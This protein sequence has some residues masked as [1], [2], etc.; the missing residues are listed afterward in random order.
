[1]GVVY[2]VHDRVRR[3]VVAL[4]TLLRA[5]P[6]DIYRLKRE[7]RSLADVAH[8]NL[9]SLYE[10]VVDGADCF[11]TME[12]V[13]GVNLVEYVR[14]PSATA[15]RRA[16]QVRHVFR[17]LVEGIDALHR[18]GKLH[19]DIKPSNIMVTPG[20]RV[21]I[22]DFGLAVDI[23]PDDDAVGESMAGTPAY[24]APERRLGMPG[25][26]RPRLVRRRRH[27]VRGAHGSRAVRGAARGDA[28]P[29]TG[30]RPVSTGRHHAGRA[31]RLERHLHGPAAPR[32][33]RAID[34]PD[35]PRGYST[36]TPR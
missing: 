8:P 12:L 32:S 2:E 5:R 34:W 27:A 28:S 14:G 18:K 25:I 17:Q 21:V 4:K 1:M 24:L 3:E 19:R 35:R 31:G 7:F 11:F 36:A 23:V 6:A 10:L 22:L 9:V 29:Q 33:R 16:E 15:S 26:G 30:N 20:G 13:H